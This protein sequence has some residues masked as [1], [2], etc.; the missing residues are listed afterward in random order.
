MQLLLCEQVQTWLQQKG[1]NPIHA[2]PPVLYTH[3]AGCSRC[4]GALVLFMTA[5][6]KSSGKWTPGKTA[7]EDC[8]RD[9]AAYIDIERE[10]SLTVAVREYPHVWWHLWTC[11]DCAE[12]YQTIVA[13]LEAEANGQLIPM[14]RASAAIQQTSLTDR[15]KFLYSVI[16]DML[17]VPPALGFAMG[18]ADTDAVLLD[19]ELAGYS[20]TLSVQKQSHEYW[21]VMA[22]V[23]PGAE[24][25]ITLI[26]GDTTFHAYLRPG[27]DTIISD[28][29]VALI[30]ADDDQQMMV[31][32]EI[33]PTP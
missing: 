25:R 9:I 19:E 28:I 23:D 33:R 22:L 27:S 31:E 13:L 21:Q 16:R 3:V 18:E 15:F 2:P 24:G 30:T 11:P 17:S 26:F 12:S 7:C 10:A 1:D 6:L 14:P 29:P 32:I 5:L 4:K 20:V 8:E